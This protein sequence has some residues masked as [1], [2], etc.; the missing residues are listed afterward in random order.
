MNNSISMQIHAH[1]SLASDRL[2]LLPITVGVLYFAC[3]IRCWS[4]R[5]IAALHIN[6][7]L[8]TLE[9]RARIF[10]YTQ[11][12]SK[13]SGE[14]AAAIRW[15]DGALVWWCELGSEVH[16]QYL[17]HFEA[18]THF[19][20]IREKYFPTN[21]FNYCALRRKMMNRLISNYLH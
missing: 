10:A 14:K 15:Y 16:F 20:D 17:K 9:S 7:T 19:D 5:A 8:I 11:T 18:F 13:W 4:Q 12:Q 3:A 6:Q 2:E 21:M 1:V